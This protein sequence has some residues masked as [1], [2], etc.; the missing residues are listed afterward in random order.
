MLGMTPS[1]YTLSRCTST[2]TPTTFVSVVQVQFQ[3][4]TSAQT[5]K[6]LHEPTA[7]TLTPTCGGSRSAGAIAGLRSVLRVS[8]SFAITV[9]ARPLSHTPYSKLSRSGC[10][11]SSSKRPPNLSPGGLSIPQEHTTPCDD[12]FG[13]LSGITGGVVYTAMYG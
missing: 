1:G 8:Q 11:F 7:V 4:C 2:G 12:F 13:A 10:V 5:N 9:T 3:S 6:T